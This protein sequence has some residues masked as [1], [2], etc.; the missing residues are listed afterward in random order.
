MNRAFVDQ[1]T[2]ILII[3][4]NDRAAVNRIACCFKHILDQQSSGI[5]LHGPGVRDR[6]DIASY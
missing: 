4:L 2:D 5:G 6:N 1:F 3:I